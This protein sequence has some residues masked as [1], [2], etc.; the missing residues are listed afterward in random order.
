M[1]TLFLHS[2]IYRPNIGPCVIYSGLSREVSASAELN[3]SGCICSS[4]YNSQT[5]EYKTLRKHVREALSSGKFIPT[6]IASMMNAV[7]AWQP[8]TSQQI[9]HVR[10]EANKLIDC[11]LCL[12][13]DETESLL[14][15]TE[16]YISMWSWPY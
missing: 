3:K 4:L 14:C 15:E 12:S 10:Y 7:I 13:S 9:G 1:C 6:D 8:L 2:S 11:Y 5:C 16:V